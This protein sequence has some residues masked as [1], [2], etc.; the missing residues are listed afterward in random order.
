MHAAGDHHKTKILFQ[1]QKKSIILCECSNIGKK[2]YK[3]YNL[4]VDFI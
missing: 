4:V 2:I 3:S 1:V